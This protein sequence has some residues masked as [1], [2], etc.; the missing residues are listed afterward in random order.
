MVPSVRSH[1][2]L[3]RLETRQCPT[4]RLLLSTIKTNWPF[5]ESTVSVESIGSQGT[6]CCDGSRA[7]SC[8]IMIRKA[9]QRS[10]ETNTVWLDLGAAAVVPWHRLRRVFYMPPLLLTSIPC[11]NCYNGLSNFSYHHIPGKDLLD[12]LLSNLY[13]KPLI[14]KLL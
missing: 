9:D 3:K 2:W 1:K 4:S 6:T 10:L 11:I 13:S 8:E 5:T 12:T 7:L 14:L